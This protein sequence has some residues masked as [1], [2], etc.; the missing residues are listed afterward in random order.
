MSE[1]APA[2][3]YNTVTQITEAIQQ[4]QTQLTLYDVV[5]LMGIVV[6][7]V[8][9]IIYILWRMGLIGKTLQGSKIS[10]FEIIGKEISS[11]NKAITA[12]TGELHKST[13]NTQLATEAHSL[14]LTKDQD[15]IP[16]LLSIPKT[17]REISGTMKR[18][19]KTLVRIDDHLHDK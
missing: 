9:C 16:I 8:S 5:I 15:N 13:V 2:L 11:M 12:M 10:S 17:M 19:D 4:S 6:M 18:L 1:S 3:D 7:A 14:I